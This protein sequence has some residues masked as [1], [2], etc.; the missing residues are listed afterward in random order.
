MEGRVA[1]QTSNRSSVEVQ[2][3]YSCKYESIK[4]FRVNLLTGEQS[5][6][7]LPAYQ[8]KNFCRWSELPGGILLLTGGGNP[9]SMQVELIDTLRECAVSSLPPMYTARRSHAALYH[10]Q[11]L[12][13]LGGH[14]YSRGT[15]SECERYVC[16]ESR[17]EVLPALPVVCCE[18]STVVLDNGLYALGGFYKGGLDTVQR[19]SLDSLTWEVMQLRLPEPA[20]SFPCFKVDTQVFLVINQTLYSFTPI[21]VEPVKSVPERIECWASH[22]SRGSLYYSWTS[23]ESLALGELTSL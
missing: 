9:A 12:Y 5:C 6:Q 8:F 15:L 13:V 19:L 3:I 22:Y 1:G 11:Y 17:W 4:L 7:K 23:I 21:Q 10:S 16:A 18:M 14:T 2:F 20:R